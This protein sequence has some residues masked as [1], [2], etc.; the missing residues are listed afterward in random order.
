VLKFV[1]ENEVKIKG[2]SKKLRLGKGVV[3]I[4]QAKKQLF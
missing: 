4:V 1:M 3:A 2:L